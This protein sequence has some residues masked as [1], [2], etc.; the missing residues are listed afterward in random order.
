[1]NVKEFYEA[2]GANYQDVIAR[3]MKDELILR[4]LN[5][6][7]DDVNYDNL[8]KNVAAGDYK[9]AFLSVHTLKGLALNLGLS[10]LGAATGELTEYLRAE[11]ND[12]EK[13]EELMVP[14]RECHKEVTE[15]LAKLS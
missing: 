4:F 7:K 10:K 15:N 2:I 8:E 5:K 9:E 6:Y 14:I 1:M 13:V 12:P 11:G 3:L